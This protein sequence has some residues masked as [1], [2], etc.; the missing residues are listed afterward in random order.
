M[1]NEADVY[2]IMEKLSI[3]AM[4]TLRKHP[5]T[6]KGENGERDNLYLFYSGLLRHA[7]HSLV[8]E[9]QRTEVR[10]KTMSAIGVD[11]AKLRRIPTNSGNMDE[12]DEDEDDEDDDDEVDD[13]ELHSAA[14]EGSQ[15]SVTS[16][17][18]QCG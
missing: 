9:T 17:V 14:E 15:G 12:I 18:H 5:R 11:L 16:E 6:V 1:I 13:D 7:A 2:T 4:R 3:P 10:R 8:L